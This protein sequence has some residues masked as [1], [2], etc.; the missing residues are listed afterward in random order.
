MRIG[1]H[2]SHE[3]FSPSE[4]LTYV[5]EAQKAGF[6]CVMSSDHLAPWSVRQGH[7]GNAWTWLGSAIAETGARAGIEFGSLAIPGGW[8]YHPVI[9]AQMIATICE[10]YPGRLGWIA[11]GSGEAMNEAVLGL[12]WP[13]KAE[14][15]ERLR[16]GVEMMRS[17]WA[18]QE[19]TIRDRDIRAEKARY[20]GRVSCPPRIFAAALSPETARWAGNWADGLIT[21]RQPPQDIERMRK[22]FQEGGGVGKPINMQFQLSWAETSEEARHHAWDQW[23]CAALSKDQC[24]NLRSPEEFDAACAHVGKDEISDYVY[25]PGSAEEL[26]QNLKKYEALGVNEV[27]LHSVAPDQAAFIRMCAKQIL[28]NFAP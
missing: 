14:R 6:A 8:R 2:A 15:H 20:W 25:I 10:M 17:L 7:A 4:L 24:A 26:V 27:Y 11:A 18:G 23:R 12:G 19:I 5:Q 1:Y 21:V 28:P 9:L 13:D 3:Q 16:Q 22:E